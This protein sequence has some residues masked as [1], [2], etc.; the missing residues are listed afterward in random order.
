MAASIARAAARCCKKIK[1]E[2]AARTAK[3]VTS[4]ESTTLKA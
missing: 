1:E 2:S 3:T 4:W